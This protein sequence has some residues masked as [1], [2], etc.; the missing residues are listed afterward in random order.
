[1]IGRE[2]FVLEGARE[3][4]DREVLEGFLTQFYTQAAQI[5]DQVILPSEDQEARI[6]EEWLRQR[7]G[8]EKVQLLV[9]RHGVKRDLLRMAAEN[10]SETLASLRAQWQADRSRHVA[11]LA[12]LQAALRLS[13][14]PNRMEAFDISNLQGTAAAG[15]MVVF[16]QGAPAKRLY[17]RF[18]IKT[19]SGQDDFASME[20]VL[21]RRFRR[22]ALAVEEAAKPGGKLDPAWGLLPDLLLIDGGR[23]QLGRAVRVLERHELSGRVPVAGLA[24]GHEELFLPGRSDPVILPRRAEALYLVQRIRDEAHRF[25]LG[26]HRSVRAKRGLVSQLD[27]IP[28]IGPSRRKALV[29]AFGDVEAIRKAGLEELMTVPGISRELAERVKAEL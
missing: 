4:A 6:I 8:G 15:S 2:Y 13:A 9:P 10:A 17:R 19:V 28:G 27:S 14:P 29:R 16:E 7:R 21:E 24:K 20:E 11:A 22:W 5:P 3:A 1:L 23:G 26:Q 12:E 18:T 25:A